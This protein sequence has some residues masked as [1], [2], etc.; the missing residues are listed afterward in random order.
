MFFVYIY[1][2]KSTFGTTQ[3]FPY[4]YPELRITFKE[5]NTLPIFPFNLY[6]YIM[7]PKIAVIVAKAK[8]HGIGCSEGLPWHIPAELK[9]FKERT[10][11]KPVIMGR[12]TF[13]SLGKPLPGRM[14]IVVSRTIKSY[15]HFDNTDVFS[16]LDDAIAAALENA[17][18]K[19]KNEIF[20]IGGSDIFEQAIPQADIVYLTKIDSECIRKANA[21][22]DPKHFDI[23]W[24]LKK[25]ETKEHEE[26]LS[27][28][29][30]S[31]EFQV[32]EKTAS[33]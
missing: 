9:Y 17:K 10:I 15:A 1:V 25:T 8:D 26:K 30:V 3:L 22:L 18:Q 31:C 20:I 16:N 24:T 23:G 2:E 21:F 32:L 13:E 11:G 33:I 5:S 7:S 28:T 12:K 6:R 19:E 27:G 29:T 4:T 14:N